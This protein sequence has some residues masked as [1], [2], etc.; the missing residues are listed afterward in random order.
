MRINPGTSPTVERTDGRDRIPRETV[1]AI[2]TMPHCHH[3]NDL[4]LISPQA[5]EA[6][7]SPANG[8]R[9]FP[10]SFCSPRLS[11]GD[12]GGLCESRKFDRLEI[13]SAWA[14]S[15]SSSPNFVGAC[16]IW[17]FVDVMMVAMDI[18]GK[19]QGP[20]RRRWE[21][22]MEWAGGQGVGGDGIS[23]C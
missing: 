12:W 11:T 13:C 19:S 7:S 8:S 15:F 17:L 22:R 1:S 3:S 6:S 2:M 20:L 9:G 5:T 10:S 21:A 14:I 18:R 4:N 16:A 23:A